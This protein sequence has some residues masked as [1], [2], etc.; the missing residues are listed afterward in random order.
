M[1]ADL[2]PKLKSALRDKNI[3]ICGNSAAGAA[4]RLDILQN[5]TDPGRRIS[6][7]SGAPLEDKNVT[8]CYSNEKDGKVKIRSS[9]KEYR[10]AYDRFDRRQS[11]CTLRYKVLVIRLL[12][13]ALTDKG[14]ESVL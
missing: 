8:L 12:L 7:Y 4:M 1:T 6:G 9:R 13:A 11:T 14:P 5:D 3:S 10:H 2:W